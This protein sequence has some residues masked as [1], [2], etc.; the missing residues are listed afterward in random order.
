MIVDDSW[1]GAVCLTGER[2]GAQCFQR[3]GVGRHV[4]VLRGDHKSRPWRIARGR[5][6]VQ[7]WENLSMTRSGWS[8]RPLSGYVS[9]TFQVL[10]RQ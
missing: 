5:P 3:Q 4:R 6:A 7:P 8:N 10:P 2:A 9:F 1:D